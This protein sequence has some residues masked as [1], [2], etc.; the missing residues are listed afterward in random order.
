MKNSKRKQKAQLTELDQ[1]FNGVE[2]TIKARQIPTI[3]YIPKCSRMFHN[4]NSRRSLTKP[5]SDYCTQDK[6][7][8]SG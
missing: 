1:A 7:N 2:I 5:E 8:K 6:N 4:Q 3:Q